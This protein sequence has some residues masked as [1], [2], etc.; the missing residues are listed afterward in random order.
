MGMKQLRKLGLMVAVSVLLNSASQTRS[1]EPLPKVEE[2]IK[3]AV[4][5]A[6]SEAQNDID[7]KKKYYF[8]RSKLTEIRNF[9]G[10]LKKSDSRINTNSPQKIVEAPKPVEPEPDKDVVVVRSPKDEQFSSSKMGKATARKFDKNQFQFNDDLVARYDF[11]LIGREMTNGY[12]LL[13]VDFAPKKKKLPE[14]G[15]RDRLINR[16]A[17]RIWVDEREYAIRSCKLT[18]LESVSIVGGIVGEAQK[19]DYSFDRERTEDGIWY[20]AD[21]KWRLEGRQVVVYRKAEYHETRTQVK[22]VE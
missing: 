16:V 7:F 12:S 5:R 17:G 2:I 11:K 22:K 21:S 14:N 10:E 18:L 19:F 4:K 3:R 8:V 13:V 9:E 1:E 6:D 15:I 20:V